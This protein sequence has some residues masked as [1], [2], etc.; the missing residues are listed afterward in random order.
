MHFS[1]DSSA[2]IWYTV[3]R[4]LCSVRTISIGLLSNQITD[5]RVS[6]LNRP[7]FYKTITRRSWKLWR[8]FPSHWLVYRSSIY[9]FLLF[10]ESLSL[11]WN[12]C[13]IRKMFHARYFKFLKATFM[14][15]QAT[16]MFL[17]ATCTCTF[18]FHLP[19][20]HSLECTWHRSSVGNT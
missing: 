10:H 19:V 16:F 18:M 15:L 2:W 8:R 1:N 20:W 4:V 7:C 3:Y 12:S 13:K 6:F 17:Q 5:L 9:H 11:S 14:F